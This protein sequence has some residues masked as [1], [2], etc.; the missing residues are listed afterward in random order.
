MTV[1]KLANPD[2]EPAEMASPMLGAYQG[3]TLGELSAKWLE[4]VHELA[5]RDVAVINPEHALEG[6]LSIR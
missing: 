2:E 4:T 3:I 1:R 5:S 6:A